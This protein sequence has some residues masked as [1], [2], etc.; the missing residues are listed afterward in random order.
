MIDKSFIIVTRNRQKLATRQERKYA[1][2][3]L[4]NFPGATLK[5]M[6]QGNRKSWGLFLCLYNYPL[7]WLLGEKFKIEPLKISNIKR[8]EYEKK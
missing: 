5:C 7:T 3:K 2:I 1:A 8:T 6:M 4:S